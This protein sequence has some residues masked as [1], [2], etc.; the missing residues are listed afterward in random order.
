M[1]NRGAV[2]NAA[3]NGGGDFA[4]GSLGAG[5]VGDAATIGPCASLGAGTDRFSRAAN[6]T[7]RTERAIATAA[8]IMTAG[9][10]GLDMTTRR[11][12]MRYEL[13]SQAQAMGA[14]RYFR[15]GI[16]SRV[17]RWESEY[18]LLIFPTVLFDV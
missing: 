8:T 9:L 2:A 1:R 14:E 4:L 17:M 18:T 3:G 13:L 11:T 12:G 5:G 7:R 6:T 10:T 15:F 16:I